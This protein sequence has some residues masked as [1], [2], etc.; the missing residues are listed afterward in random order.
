MYICVNTCVCLEKRRDKSP[1]N[2]RRL[3]AVVTDCISHTNRI[4]QI[5]INTYVCCFLNANKK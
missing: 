2:Y 5:Y 1:T 3:T 4:K